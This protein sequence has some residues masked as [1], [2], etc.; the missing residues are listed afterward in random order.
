MTARERRNS[1]AGWLA[2]ALLLAAQYVLFRAAVERE[3]AWGYPRMWDQAGFLSQVYGF[4]E[5]A[6]REGLGAALGQAWHGRFPQGVLMPFLAVP[7]L[8]GL[9]ASRLSALTLI[10]L[11]HALLQVL[12]VVL[13]RRL[14]G[15][16]TAPALAIGLLLASHSPAHWG[17]LF[18]FRLDF[19]AQCLYGVWLLAVLR[20]DSFARR[21][22]ALV[23]GAVGGLLVLLRYV[24]LAYTLGTLAAFACVELLVSRG[25]A[26]RARL[27]GLAWSTALLVAVA[28]PVLFASRAHLRAYY[29]AGHVEQGATLAAAAG[30]HTRAQAWGYYPRSLAVE[31]AGTLYLA[32]A[33]LLLLGFA[34]VA[35]RTT[36]AE[37]TASQ[38][39][40]DLAAAAR[41]L[42]C[43]ALVPITILMLDTAKSPIVVGVS[44][45]ALSLLL[46]WP[47]VALARQGRA[48]RA[49]GAAAALVLA[50]GAWHHARFLRAPGPLRDDWPTHREATRLH[51]LLARVS[52]EQGW[53]RPIMLFDSL[54]EDALPWSTAVLAYERYGQSIDPL[55]PLGGSPWQ[56][57]TGEQIASLLQHAHFVVVAQ[58]TPR[59][60]PDVSVFER[61][62]AEQRARIAAACRAA[63]VRLDTFEVGRRSLA[64]WARAAPVIVDPQ[65]PEREGWTWITR[66]GGLTVQASSLLWRARPRLRL[67]GVGRLEWVG[68]SLP[69]A[70]A[71]LLIEGREP[72]ALAVEVASLGQRYALRV[73][74]APRWLDG[75]TSARVRFDFERGFRPSEVGLSDETRE[76]VTATPQRAR[77]QR[78]SDDE[79]TLREELSP[80]PPPVALG[81]AG[82]CTLVTRRARPRTHAAPGDFD[83]D[84]ES[85]LLLRSE[86]EGHLRAWFIERA[87]CAAQAAFDPQPGAAWRVAAA[88]DFDGDGRTDLALQDDGGGQVSFWRLGGA[89]G[90]QRLGEPVELVP[91]PQRRLRLVAAADADADGRPDLLFERAGGLSVEVWTL[92]GL[93]RRDV[94]R[95]AP[96]SAGLRWV[97]AGALD[98]DGDGRLD[99][100][101]QNPFTQRLVVWWLGPGGVRRDGRFTTPDAPEP[102]ASL[103]AL[104]G[105]APQQ[106]ALLAWAH[107]R[108]ASVELWRL[109][110][111]AR[112]TRVER[113]RV[114]AWRGWRLAGPR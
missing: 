45:P 63:F 93:R 101:W 89:T 54:R 23:A 103:G 113:L 104:V 24:T 67:D 44:V 97:S 94:M 46:V 58:G 12:I 90:T 33:A 78:A 47:A 100:L 5:L 27:R 85:D 9:G 84:G 19:M 18:D 82:P 2:L 57:V 43:A 60:L 110:R 109:G 56:A 114:D 39:A 25:A 52:I 66:E 87:R 73:T 79:Q 34:A 107:E 16:F 48:R 11:H 6:R 7:L 98:V 102:G 108:P 29:W 68:G 20:S 49:L 21:R 92:A 62:V 83:G 71:H 53:H 41:L 74:L 88:A 8:R 4:D 15:G 106:E 69:P 75:A 86:G 65:I 95:P 26:R 35:R 30:I 99:L 61:S 105:R 10:F 28:G 81:E 17:G 111:G 70:R 112:R 38:P 3:I 77:L 72:R 14:T 37:R 76:L 40:C 1:A 59:R 51:E 64:V 91:R 32:L 55:V 96:D 80:G 50:A 31:H 42:C 13:L 36:R 22:G